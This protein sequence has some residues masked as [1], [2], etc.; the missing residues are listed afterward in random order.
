MPVSSRCRP[1]RYPLSLCL[2]ISLPLSLSLSFSHETPLGRIFNVAN[3]DRR[4]SR[5]LTEVSTPSSDSAVAISIRSIPSCSDSFDPGPPRTLV[6]GCFCV[7]HLQRSEQKQP[8]TKHGQAPLLCI[9]LHIFPHLQLSPGSAQCLFS[10]N[11]DMLDLFLLLSPA[12][13]RCQPDNQPLPRMVAHADAVMH[14]Y[15]APD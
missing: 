13:A 4:R 6:Q 3:K 10:P 5:L 14:D 8:R 11:S 1:T 2:S 15:R 7:P 9:R 12:I